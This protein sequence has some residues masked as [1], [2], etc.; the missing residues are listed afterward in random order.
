MRPETVFQLVKHGLTALKVPKPVSP[1]RV[2]SAVQDVPS[3][4][5]NK[6][7]ATTT[8]LQTTKGSPKNPG[9]MI[10]PKANK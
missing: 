8:K 1:K 7:T 2:S 5:G 10:L 9:K 6:T 4:T 3:V